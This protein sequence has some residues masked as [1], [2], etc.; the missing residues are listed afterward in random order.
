ME[1]EFEQLKADYYDLNLK[2]KELLQTSATV[3]SENR[4][5]LATIEQMRED[6]HRVE[7]A[8]ASE[9]KDFLAKHERRAN[10]L[11]EN[12]VSLHERVENYETTISQYDQFRGKLEANLLKISQQSATN[13]RRN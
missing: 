11:E 12:L 8:A 5:L 7:Q 1:K 9:K 6:K 2:Q 13:T 4:T 10:E 3:E